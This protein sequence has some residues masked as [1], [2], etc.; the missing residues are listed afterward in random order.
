MSGICVSV[1][2]EENK[3]EKTTYPSACTLLLYTSA[4]SS[5]PSTFS[6]ISLFI[7]LARV[8][9]LMYAKQQPEAGGAGGGW[10]EEFLLKNRRTWA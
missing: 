2:V 3:D 5:P 10:S 8:I 7:F 6:G 4:I 9:S 1:R